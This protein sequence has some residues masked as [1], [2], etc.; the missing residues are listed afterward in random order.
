MPTSGRAS[1]ATAL[2]ALLLL[3]SACGGGGGGSTPISTPP[4]TPA[5]TIAVSGATGPL[6]AGTTRTF[7]AVVGN[8]SN[9]SVTWSVV[10]AGGGSIATNGT[11]TAPATPGTYTVKATSVADTTKS[12]TASVTVIAAPVQ[13]TVTAPAIVSAGLAGYTASV[14]AQTGCTYTW[15]VTNGTLTAGA[16]TPS[17]TFTAGTT[18]T[19]DLSCV[20]TN[21]AGT[22][23]AAGVASVAI[24]GTPVATSLAVSSTSP[25][26]GDTITLTPTFTGGVATLGTAGAGSS[27]IATSVT[28]GT[29]VTTPAITGP[30]T[31]TL[32]VSNGAGTVVSLDSSPVTPQTV[33]VSTPTTGNLNVTAAGGSSNT[34]R[35]FTSTVTGAL[36][37]SL[38]W[39]V[40][41]IAGGNSTVGTI[42]SGG[43]YSAGSALGTHTVKAASVA[44]PT[45]SATATVTIVAAPVVTSFVA[46]TASP[47]HGATVT[48]TPT[49]AF[50]TAQVGT[51]GSGSSD[52]SASPTSGAAITTPALSAATTYTLTVTNT[53]GTVATATATVTPQAVVVGTPTTSNLNVTEATG[54][55]NTSRTF[56]SSVTGALDTTLTWSVDNIAGGNS[57]VGTI[58]SGGV[59]TA[60]S[61]LGTHTI[62]AA[63]V[64]DPAQNA[65]ATVTVVAAPVATSC[66]ASTA[67]PLYGDTVTV[68]PTFSAGSATV[69]TTGSGSSDVSAS[70]TSGAAIT[71]PALTAAKTYTLTVTNTAGTV[72][73]ASSVLVT[74]QAVA[75]ST[76]TTSNLNV[77]VAGG[78]DNTSR[79]FSASA[80]N[81]ANTAVTWSVDAIAGGN[82][83]VGTITSGG[84]YSSGSALGNHSVTA[85]SVAD[86]TK[87]ASAT[88]TVVA[89]PNASFT[90]TA[91]RTVGDTALVESGSVQSGMTYAWTLTGNTNSNT[92]AITSGASTDSVTFDA[93]SPAGTFSLGLTVTN[94]AGTADTASHTV[95]VVA[96]PVATSLTAAFG[97]VLNGDKV[98]LTP[99]FSNG[100]AVI[101][102]AGSGSTQVSASATTGVGVLSTAVTGST[103]FTLTVTN[104]AGATATAT[105]SVNKGAATF[106]ASAHSLFAE[107]QRHSAIELSDGTVLIVGGSNVGDTFGADGDLNHT[108]MIYGELYTPSTDTFTETTGALPLGEGRRNHI[109]VADS[110]KDF[111]LLAGGIHAPANSLA[112]GFVYNRATQTFAATTNTMVTPRENHGAILLTTGA[113]AGKVLIV[114]GQN[115]V[116]SSSTLTTDVE[117]FDFSTGLFSALV[118]SAGTPAVRNYPVLT[119]LNDGKVLITGGRDGSA[120]DLNTAEVYDPVANTFTAVSNTMTDGRSFHTA[121]KLQDGTVLVAGGNISTASA[122]ADLY[123]PNT[124]SFTQVGGT[125]LGARY[126]HT[127]VLLPDGLVLLSGGHDGSNALT[128]VKVYDPIG[129]TFTATT[130][131]AAL[132]SGRRRATA[133]LINNSKVLIVGGQDGSNGLAS[134]ELY[135]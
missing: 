45:K 2:A 84:V 18:G 99:T 98:T 123:D 117:L 61:A 44:D 88:V 83:T 101:G 125:S 33:A 76:P 31:Y 37:A 7:T 111:V 5:V 4:P 47:L 25:L 67:S 50:G 94:A 10:E 26:Y 110:A 29:P 70:P 85:T 22:A 86:N 65:T 78:S 30:V 118:P 9:T 113:N 71:T 11:Y 124:N 1:S 55:D 59:Y 8:A 82:S 92:G 87:S 74:P 112:T 46:S 72:A 39:S 122:T 93:G 102:N 75:V 127:A 96:A 66:V 77:T 97:T 68:T 109:A 23:S 52:L 36:D 27:N 107:R 130:G 3:M 51:S 13:P 115:T 105:A 114:G 106:T 17:I 43:V 131:G 62:K 32:T 49:Y 91:Y 95:N 53:A 100:T 81:A 63:S 15:T 103:T 41:D 20:V 38:A 69:G 64:A 12:A 56:A 90:P 108:D 28:S 40:D 116:A 6:T 126:G 34:S 21:A 48:V 60:G 104:Q 132:A 19:V 79:T 57:T 42:T 80:G 73:T 58:T 35:T 120:V 128:T 54:A 135:Q 89:Q 129:Q 121:T 24:A 119:L 134:A 16:G 14:A 133:T